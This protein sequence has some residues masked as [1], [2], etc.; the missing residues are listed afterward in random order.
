[1][2]LEFPSPP[3]AAKGVVLRR[4]VAGDVP[5]IAAACARPEMA[6]FVPLL[7]SP[8]TEEHAAGFVAYAD[9]AWARGTGAPFAIA[10][11]GGGLLGA[12]ELHLSDA[13]PGAASVGYWLRP[14]ARGRGAATIALGLVSRWAFDAL[15]IQRLQLT[16]DP[17]NL[18]SQRVAERAR[19]R[20]E[21]LFRAWLRT[22]GGRRDTVIY[23]LLPDD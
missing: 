18:A 23:S 5:A 19:F 9:D 12:I 10:D 8:Y 3:L 11:S 7:P 1:V 13:D 16:T 4:F 2:L 15:A 22:P 20:R 14:E 6:R 17:A 21:G